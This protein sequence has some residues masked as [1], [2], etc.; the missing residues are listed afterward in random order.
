MLRKTKIAAVLSILAAGPCFS[1]FYIGAGLG[2]EGASFSQKSDVVRPLTFY[3]EDHNHFAGTGGFGTL[4]AGYSWTFNRFYIAAEGNA[5]ISSVKYKLTNEE[6]LNNNFSKTT[7]T[8][9]HSEGIS[10]LPGFYLRPDT[11]FYGRIAY[12]NGRIKIRE[13][14]PTIRSNSLNRDGLRYGLGLRQ[15]ITDR[16]VF[17]M[18]YSQIHYNDIKSRVFEPMGNV[19]KS[20]R[21]IPNSAQVAF[22]VIYKFGVPIKAYIK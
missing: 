19:T 5:N 14:D 13:S 22:G 21:I 16:W 20:T 2:P 15:D 7:F 3:V 11:L 8:I 17:M 10:I 1:G 9:P 12:A 6:F 4:F 18:D